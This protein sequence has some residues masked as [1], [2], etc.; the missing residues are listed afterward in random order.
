[1][2]PKRANEAEHRNGT[3]ERER[4]LLVRA[5]S[6]LAYRARKEREEGLTRGPRTHVQ[7]AEKCRRHT[8]DVEAV[9]LAL[10][11][12]GAERDVRKGIGSSRTLDV[13]SSVLRQEELDKG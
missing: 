11:T 3:R 9:L 6:L 12:D 8:S 4:N 1:V 5:A 7:M 10:S 13:S 2:K